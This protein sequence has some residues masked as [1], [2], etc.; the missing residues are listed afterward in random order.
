MLSMP[1][2]NDDAGT[3][4][5][6]SDKTQIDR[7]DY[8]EKMHFKLIKDAEGVSLERSSFSESANDVGN[9]R[10]AS[11]TSGFATPGYKNSQF[12]QPGVDDEFALTSKTFSPDN[13]GYEDV[14]QITYKLAQPGMIANLTV[15]N[16][17]GVLIKKLIKNETL[18]SEGCFIWDGFNESSQKASTGIYIVYAEFF[19]VGGRVKKFRKTFALAVKL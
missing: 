6:L 2:F 9:F 11:S 4:I 10:S 5:L 19:D 16:D 1:S 14:L 7:F 3:V 18:N 15:Y 13:D 12:L 17:Q 8:S